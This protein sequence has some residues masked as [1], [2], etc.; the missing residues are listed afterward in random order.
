MHAVLALTLVFSLGW[1]S[2]N[3]YT[4]LSVGEAEKPLSLTSLFTGNVERY[5]PGDHVKERNI[6]V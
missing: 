3:M 5:S 2:A 1:L 4:S 6:H